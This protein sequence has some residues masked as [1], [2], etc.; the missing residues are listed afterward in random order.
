MKL[1]KL[2]ADTLIGSIAA[3]LVPFVVACS[4]SSRINPPWVVATK[5]ELGTVSLDTSRIE[6]KA[7]GYRI[8]IQG[9]FTEPA[10]RPK[11]GGPAYD[12]MELTLD[13]DCNGRRARNING[14]VFDSLRRP[15]DRE[16]YQAQWQDFAQNDLGEV[17]L[18]D[19]C[20]V[21]SHF[22]PI[23]DARVLTQ[24]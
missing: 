16:T 3:L 10:W 19:L 2:R 11:P 9:Q 7:P 13:I 15:V 6:S 24:A 14:I 1:S 18:S 8:H 12:L 23:H 4:T 22:R 20:R 21:L 5:S 17:I